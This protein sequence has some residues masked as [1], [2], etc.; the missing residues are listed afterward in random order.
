[1]ARVI[2]A[3]NKIVVRIIRHIGGWH[4][5]IFVPRDIYSR[6]I[7]HLIVGPGRNRKSGNIASA[8]IKHDVHIRRE[9]RLRMLIYG[10]SWISPPEKGLW[11]WSPIIQLHLNL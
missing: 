7:I 5:N 4:R 11:L 9:D 6:G 3:A 10:D 8:V 2:I 1:M